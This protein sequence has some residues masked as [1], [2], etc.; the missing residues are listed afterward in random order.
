[1]AGFTTFLGKHVALIAVVSIFLVVGVMLICSC[2]PKGTTTAPDKPLASTYTNEPVADVDRDSVA[3][4]VVAAVPRG[5]QPFGTYDPNPCPDPFASRARV[6]IPQG[7]S[8]C[9]ALGSPSTCAAPPQGSSTSLSVDPFDTY[10]PDSRALVAIPQGPSTC[11]KL[12]TCPSLPFSPTRGISDI[13]QL[14]VTPPIQGF[15]K[16]R[17]YGSCEWQN[18]PENKSDENDND[19]E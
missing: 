12:G 10:D 15:S 1:M 16:K 8:T 5:P 14:V 19:S 9:A 2:I 13:G 17:E 6:V 7:P 11:A 4:R 3:D 18:R